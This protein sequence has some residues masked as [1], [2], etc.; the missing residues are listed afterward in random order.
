MVVARGWEEVV[1]E[2]YKV[3]FIQ[4]EYVLEIWIA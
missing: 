3:P 2:E 4:D 1:V